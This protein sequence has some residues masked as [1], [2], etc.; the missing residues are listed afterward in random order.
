[1]ENDMKKLLF[2][3]LLLPMFVSAQYDSTKQRQTITAY[4]Y[5]W[6]NGKFGTLVIP[7]DT[8]KMAVK[9]SNALA[10]VGGKLWRYTGH[11]WEN[12]IN[13]S[14]PIYVDTMFRQNDSLVYMKNGVEYN[15][16]ALNGVD[17]IWMVDGGSDPDTLRYRFLG[18]HVTIGVIQGGSGSISDGDKGDITVSSSGSVWTIDN[19]AVTN[20]KINDVA[21][22]KITSVPDAAAD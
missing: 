1:M 16:G 22:S 17:S 18:A 15:L 12:T 3:L 11:F 13:V 8:V 21:W 20:T 2:L 10:F 9:D 14:L 4:G 19:N 6:K 5:D 7:A